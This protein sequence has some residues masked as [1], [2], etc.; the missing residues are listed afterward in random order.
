MAANDLLQFLKKIRRT[1]ANQWTACC[2]AHIDKSPSLAIRELDDGR[3][4]IKCFGGCSADDILGSLGL[5]FDVLYPPRAFDAKRETRPFSAADV[6]RCIAKESLVVA[7]HANEMRK[8]NLT[9]SEIKRV[10]QA[11]SLIQGSIEASGIDMGNWK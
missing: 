9:E 4:L 2:P 1:G 11:A 6:L 5:E 7:A 3:V 10:I 8:R